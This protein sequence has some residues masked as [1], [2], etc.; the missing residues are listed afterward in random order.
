[1]SQQFRIWVLIGLLA[2]APGAGRAAADKGRVE[3]ARTTSAG[4]VKKFQVTVVDGELRPTEIT[5]GRGDRVS[6]TFKSLDGTYRLRMKEF[7][8]RAEFRKGEDVTI[9]IVATERGQYPFRCTK[10]RSVRRRSKNGM[11]VVK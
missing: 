10:G 11:I 9:E 1:M 3:P 5:I 8:I 4:Y 7:G 6:I 2:A